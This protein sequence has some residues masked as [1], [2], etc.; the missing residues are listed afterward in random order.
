MK[1]ASPQNHI[2][3]LSKRENEV[4]GLILQGLSNQQIAAELRV[5]EK[6]VEKHLT[7]VYRKIGVSSRA[8]A[9]LWGMSQ[10]RGI[11]T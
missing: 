9:V 10:G 1:S 2:Q 8:E 4:L 7:S 3:E 5:S 11:P 6:T